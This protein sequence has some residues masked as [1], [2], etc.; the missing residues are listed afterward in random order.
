MVVGALHVES[1]GAFKAK[2]DPILIVD[3]HRVEPSQVS[4]ERVQLVPGWHSQV[5]KPHH[6]IEL[7]EFATHVRPELARNSSSRL[8]VDAVPDV[9]RC[10]IRQRPDHNLA[11]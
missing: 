9:P 3:S 2:Y 6:R 11:L 10:L 1:V 8:A 4:A 5:L 7:I